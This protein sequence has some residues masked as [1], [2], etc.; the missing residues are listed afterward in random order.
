MTFAIL[1]KNVVRERESEEKER[2]QRKRVE[3]ER[4]EEVAS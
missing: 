4:G 2:Y 1:S 3:K